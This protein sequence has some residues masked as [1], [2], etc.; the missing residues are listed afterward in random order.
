MCFC[1]CFVSLSQVRY[2][3]PYQKREGGKCLPLFFGKKKQDSNDL[4]AS[5]QWTLAATSANTGGY[6]NLRPFPGEDANR[7]TVA[8]T[9]KEGE[10][11]ASL[12]L[13]GC[14]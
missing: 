1:R 14:S 10:A 6:L 11:F 4:N 7:G 3:H 12:F 13:Y 2:E 9:N 5:V 8:R